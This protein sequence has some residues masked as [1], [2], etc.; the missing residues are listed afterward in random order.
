MRFR[1]VRVALGKKSILPVLLNHDIRCFL[2]CV[3]LAANSLQAQTDI[4]FERISVDDGL[5]QSSIT[6]MIQDKFG[7]LW[8]GTLDGLNRY[9]GSSFT[10]YRNDYKSNSLPERIISRLF[11]DRQERLWV[12]Y[13]NGISRYDA[14]IDRFF[15]Y[16][17]EIGK[18]NLFIRDCT[19]IS[20][21]LATLSTNQ[22]VFDFNPATGSVLRNETFGQ[23]SGQSIASVIHGEGGATWLSTDSVLWRRRDEK[24]EW[25]AFF[26]IDGHLTVAF[27]EDS[28]K[29][30]VRTANK[31]LKY[32]PTTDK[33][34][35]IGD[36]PENQWPSSEKIFKASNGNLWIAHGDITI[37]DKDDRLLN[38]LFHASQDPNSL[39]GAFA[40]EIYETKD[41]VIWVGTNGLGLNKFNPYRSAFSYLGHFPGAQVSLRD[42]FVTSVFTEDDTTLLVG[43]LDGFNVIN[44]AERKSFHF[45]ILGKNG[46]PAQVRKIFKDG[47]GNIWLATTKGMMAFEKTTIRPS[48]N[49]ILDNP[50]LSIYDVVEITGSKFLLT[51][52]KSIYLWN[53]ETAIVDEIHNFG[54]PVLRLINN[55][56]WFESGD[57]LKILSL[58]DRQIVK[59]FPIHGTDST[60]APL[61]SVKCLYQDS[62]KKIWVGTDGGGLS[63]YDT[64]QQTFQ[65]FR[66]KD[67]LANN[68][69][70][71]ILEDKAGHLWLST[72]RGLTVFDRKTK[73]AIRNFSKTD[74]LQSNE[75]N[76]RAFFSSSSGKLYFGGI[77]GLSF[78]DPQRALQ[79]PSFTPKTILTGF[80]LNH[81][82]Q[83][84]REHDEFIS[85]FSDYRI[86]LNW[87]E[88]NF[89]F[90]IA[91]LGFTF[92]SGVQYQ[93]KLE[94]FDKDWNFIGNQ[95][96]IT[97]T[98]MAAGTYTLRIKSG[99][100][101]GSW[102]QDGMAIQIV[103]VAPFW[104]SAWF[105]AGGV[106]LL[107]FSML[108]IYYQRIRF[109]KRRAFVLQSMVEE[110]TREIQ[111]QG[112]EIAT[113]NEE[114]AA[115]A[116]TLENT[117]SE[118][119]LRVESRTRRLRQLNEELVDQNSQLEQFAFI[120]AH[121]IRGPIARIRGLIS[122]I[123]PDNLQ[124][125]TKHLDTSV[126]NLDEVISDLT[127]VLNITHTVDK[128]FEM[129]AVKEQL[130]LVLSMLSTE[131]QLLNAKVDSSGFI[132]VR[133][134]GL[135]A[136]FQSIFYNLVH[137]ALKYADHTRGVH[138]KIYTVQ[139]PESTNLIFE[140]NG[141][142]I[143]MRYA[144]DKIFKLH[145]RF[146][147]NTVGKG[148]GLF[149]VKTQVKI[150][151][152]KIQVESEL[153][154]GT[155]FTMEFKNN[156]T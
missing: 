124:E 140:D 35:A 8:I 69:V 27:F 47:K 149:L 83:E 136:Y 64:E 100:S 43:T 59:T 12:A 56:Y 57:R 99:N 40:S 44:L 39:S 137:N 21:S 108:F 25:S 135:K 4:R 19:F 31:L 46:K 48:G 145:Q 95:S 90:D 45:P 65:H 97:F 3:F 68:V 128:K 85:L 148:L 131:I 42:N 26:K 152:G 139:T 37:F 117:N 10:V 55:Q 144:K 154:K 114:L 130:S 153:N 82:R 132:D 5:S 116:E 103:I 80:Y 133:L 92:P 41:G 53:Q 96:R 75:F 122:L 76:T 151:R 77:N 38:R 106:A 86:K 107:I 146:N 7:Y 104:K 22:G 156:A 119:E 81:I 110:R 105:I 127:T 29:L 66:E 6:S 18:K 98:N 112:E 123:Q 125:L 129:V 9:D 11:L 72:N 126:N 113:Q 155:T 67:G 138:I 101:F 70:Y 63:L 91:G 84:Q 94:G 79:I 141:I 1:I 20:D 15:N 109:L 89:G 16:P 54:S 147:T 142:G 120:T 32:E 51:T 50:E 134:Y 61:T 111:R 60:T 24:S 49:L 36:I 74:G 71:G 62:E 33:L 28:K 34:I 143:D 150:M 13:R 23:F 58:T 121:N 93:Y 88:R 2:T 73:K 14:G 118:L 30:Y 78:F 87:D 115:Q 52:N 102:E 17:L